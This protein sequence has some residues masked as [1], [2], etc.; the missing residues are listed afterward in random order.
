[1]AKRTTGTFTAAGQNS[2]AILGKEAEALLTGTFTAT[3]VP[4][5]QDANGNWAPLDGVSMTAPAAR[6]FEMAVSRPWRL[7]VTAF[8]AGPIAYELAGEEFPNQT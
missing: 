7:A 6:K 3:V 2:A 4:Q 5:V 8:T 1:M